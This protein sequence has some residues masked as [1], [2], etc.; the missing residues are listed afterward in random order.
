MLTVANSIPAEIV[1]AAER[2][3]VFTLL[4]DRIDKW[5]GAISGNDHR[6]ACGGT[7]MEQILKRKYSLVYVSTVSQA[8][9]LDFGLLEYDPTLAD[10]PKSVYMR[11]GAVMPDSHDVPW[12]VDRSQ[13]AW[14][15]F[16]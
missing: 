12:L 7:S 1:K 8:A 9:G 16:S 5:P 14:R 6:H 4:K 2:E 10:K 15:S 11:L 3:L 13:L